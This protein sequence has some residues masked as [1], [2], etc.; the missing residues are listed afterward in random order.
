MRRRRWA[1]WCMRRRWA[2]SAHAHHPHHARIAIRIVAAVWRKHRRPAP[3]HTYH[4]FL[5]DNSVALSLSI[6]RMNPHCLFR[7]PRQVGKT[8]LWRAQPT[9]LKGRCPVHTLDVAR[10]CTYTRHRLPSQLTPN[11]EKGGGAVDKRT[12]RTAAWAAAVR[13]RGTAAVVAPATVAYWRKRMRAAGP[14]AAAPAVALPDAHAVG[15]QEAA[16]VALH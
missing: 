10:Q 13:R 4:T 16:D 15:P 7:E 8:P 9:Q 1:T 3:Y 11:R 5:S 14:E 12:S 6:L 2:S